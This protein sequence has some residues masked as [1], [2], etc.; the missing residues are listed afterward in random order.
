MYLNLP[1][2]ISG[3]CPDQVGKKGWSCFKNQDIVQLGEDSMFRFV[4]NIFL[5]SSLLCIIIILYPKLS[6]I[7]F[8]SKSLRS[9]IRKRKW[10]FNVINP[11]QMT[12]SAST[13]LRTYQKIGP[14]QGCQFDGR[15]SGGTG[16]IYYKYWQNHHW[17][18]IIIDGMF[19]TSTHR[20]L[21]QYNGG[22]SPYF[23]RTELHFGRN[24]FWHQCYLCDDRRI[25]H[26]HG[27]VWCRL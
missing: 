8:I 18:L 9:G 17:K 10:G 2:L 20:R 23:F 15:K 3:P 6:D 1:G 27:N 11:P 7:K 4:V 13:V 16:G 19:K 26:G 12:S 21:L 24:R 5:I 25:L 14:S 22:M